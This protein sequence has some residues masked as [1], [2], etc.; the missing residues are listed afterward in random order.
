MSFS[1]LLSELGPPLKNEKAK[2]K[3]FRFWAPPPYE[4]LDTRL[5]GGEVL[6]SF[7]QLFSELA[8]PLKN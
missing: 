3:A 6:M 1:Q 8:P 5:G 2:K 7:S 4:F